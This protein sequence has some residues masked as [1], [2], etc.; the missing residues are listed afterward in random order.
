MLQTQLVSVNRKREHFV[1]SPV[2][3]CMD[4]G[5]GVTEWVRSNLPEWAVPLFEVLSLPGDLPVVVAAVALLCLV[6]AGRT[7]CSLSTTNIDRHSDSNPGTNHSLCSNR[8][9]FVIGVILG[10]LALIVLLESVFEF[11]RPPEAWHAVTPSKYGFPSGHTMAATVTWGAIALWVSNGSHRIRF[12]I[13]G[14]IVSIVAIA[15]ISLGVHYFVDVVASVVFGCLYLL[16]LASYLQD[17]PGPTFGLAIGI[18]VLALAVTGGNSRAVLALTGTIGAGVGWW[19][20]E[21]PFVSRHI[22]AGVGQIR[23]KS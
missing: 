11:S 18:A 1:G 4:R 20:L 17:R 6:N 8:T 15:R 23:K 22:V 2:S 5:I 14:G 19:L 3:Y 7:V 16:F 13:A 12:F 21:R 9:A 10:G